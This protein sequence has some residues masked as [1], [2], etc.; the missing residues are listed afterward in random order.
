[1][2][3]NLFAIAG[4]DAMLLGLLVAGPLMAVYG[5]LQ[6]VGDLR[7]APAKKI[8]SRLRGKS[9]GSAAVA[10]ITADDLRKTGPK[11]DG[12][13]A[14]RLAKFKAAERLQA[15]LDQANLNW[16][17][18]QL[19]LNLTLVA[20]VIVAALLA[21]GLP[22][23]VG[24]VCGAAVFVGPVL[25]LNLKRRSRINK[26]VAQ[27]PDV[28]ELLSQA[29]RAGHSLASGMQ[30]VSSELADPAG[31]EFARVFQEQNL[32]L[33]IE[34]ALKSL[35]DRMDVLDVRFFVTAVLIQRQTGGDLAEV[36][37]KI[38]AVI[39]DRIK[40]QQTVSALT[41]EG[42]LSG[43]VLLALPLI[44]FGAMLKINYD[45]AM[46]LFNHPTGQMMATFAVVSMIMGWVM[47]KK[48]INVKV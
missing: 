39:R 28:F 11:A 13:V 20:C 47:I 32:G 15:I 12:T 19:L 8:A 36:L 35:A 9:S 37:D 30:V 4:G 3:S 23:F 18:G 33:K 16:N 14:T 17:A 5:I 1:M 38:S 43:Y 41:A 27:L 24:L 2:I 21:I 29:L 7:A 44:V 48:I 25:Y 10:K 22:I 6:L 45:Y 40:L 26:L 31:T 46:L 42:R 34:D